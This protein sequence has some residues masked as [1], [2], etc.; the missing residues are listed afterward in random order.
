MLHRHS[1]L[2]YSPS[3]LDGASASRCSLD[4]TA[5]P[6]AAQPLIGGAPDIKKYSEISPPVPAQPLRSLLPQQ[7]PEG[8]A[9]PTDQPLFSCSRTGTYYG[10]IRKVLALGPTTQGAIDGVSERKSRQVEQRSE[11]TT[12]MRFDFTVKLNYK[13]SRERVNHLEIVGLNMSEI[14]DRFAQF[15]QETLMEEARQVETK[16]PLTLRLPAQM[17]AQLNELATLVQ[18]TRTEVVE[19]LLRTGIHEAV[20]GVM[21]ASDKPENVTASVQQFYEHCAVDGVKKLKGGDE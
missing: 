20:I 12:E 17:V 7:T 2:P 18:M 21:E 19:Q 1:L 15:Y 16:H 3:R 9:L 8:K 4:S 13:F 10:R 6:P 5:L 11:R 14:K